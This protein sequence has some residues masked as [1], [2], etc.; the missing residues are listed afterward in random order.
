[1]T[2]YRV[3]YEIEV[4]AETPLEA[5]RLVDDYMQ[6][7]VRSYEPYFHIMDLLTGKESSIDLEDYK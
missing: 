3:L 7:D 4:E 5:A 2:T 6:R 1:M